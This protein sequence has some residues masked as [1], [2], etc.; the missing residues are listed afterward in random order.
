LRKILLVSF[1]VFF[2][3]ASVPV[4]L[5]ASANLQAIQAHLNHGIKIALNGRLWQPSQTP[6]TYNGSTYLPLRAVGEALGAQITWD[7]ATQTIGIT[8]DGAPE[9]ENYDAILEFPADR[10]PTVAAHIASAILAGESSV[11]TIDRYGADQ[12]R[13]AS[14]DGIPT[15]DGYDRDE[16]PMAVCA[17]GGSG[18]SVAYI[19]PAENRGAGGWVGNALEKYPDGTRVKFIVSFNELD[20]DE[21]RA[22]HG[23]SEESGRSKPFASCAEARAAGMAPLYRGDPGYSERLDRDGDG[24]AC[25]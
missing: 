2:M 8:T 18:A 9:A 4:V 1:V 23:P 10:F 17:E 22:S 12:R 14:L 6:I 15:R 11:C 19:N 3:I 20:A 21:Q 5:N 24:V 16:W 7:G 25:E 13:E